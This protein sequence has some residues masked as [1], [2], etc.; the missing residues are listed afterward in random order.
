MPHR[1]LS[2][3]Y[4]G[5]VAVCL[6]LFTSHSGFAA[7]CPSGGTTIGGALA[8][9]RSVT[10]AI[11]LLPCQTLSVTL[12]GSASNNPSGN[13]AMGVKIRTAAHEVLASS[14]FVCGMS[15]T[16]TVPA[17]NA[18]NGAPL[19]GTRGVEGLAAEIV[20]STGFFNWFGTP[21]ATYTLTL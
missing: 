9:N 13:A 17:P 10:W 1:L 2:A 20:V 21:P 19:P 15:C 4:P 12:T 11:T 16:V 8:E 3:A 5:L 14:D 6:L 18:A 7:S